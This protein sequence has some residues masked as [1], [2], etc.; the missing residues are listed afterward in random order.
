MKDLRSKI[1]NNFKA[2][3]AKKELSGIFENLIK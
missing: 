2:K 3:P 1:L